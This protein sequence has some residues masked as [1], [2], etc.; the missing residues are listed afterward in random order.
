MKIHE[1]GPHL[2]RLGAITSITIDTKSNSLIN[3]RRAQA[4]VTS[5]LSNKHLASAFAYC[6]GLSEGY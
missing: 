3:M 1:R 2:P 4:V 6:I 5:A